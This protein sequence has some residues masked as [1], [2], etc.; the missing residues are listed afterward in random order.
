MILATERNI[1]EDRG[2]PSRIRDLTVTRWDQPL[3]SAAPAILARRVP[4]LI[5]AGLLDAAERDL[6]WFT[7]RAANTSEWAPL[8]SPTRI[9]AGCRA[10]SRAQGHGRRRLIAA[11]LNCYPVW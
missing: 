9:P 2:E 5:Q 6:E 11:R 10:G 8:G 1:F 7:H 3:P 4:L